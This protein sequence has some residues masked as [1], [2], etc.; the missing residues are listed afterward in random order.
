MPPC[1]RLSPR[2][3]TNGSLPRNGS[4]VR[5]ACARPAGSS[6]TMYVISTPNR[7]PS[8]AAARIS[9]PVSGAM[10]I[11]TSVMPAFAIASMP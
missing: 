6:W 11:P 2:Y 1:S 8:P 3:M 9:S 7:E 10:M 4:A 5:T